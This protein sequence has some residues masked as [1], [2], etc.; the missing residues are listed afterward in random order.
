MANEI[1]GR[2]EKINELKPQEKREEV[3]KLTDTQTVNTNKGCC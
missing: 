1:K 3:R 2:V